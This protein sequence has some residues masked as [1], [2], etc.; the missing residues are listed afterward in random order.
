MFSDELDDHDDNEPNDENETD[1]DEEA[2]QIR[3]TT[4]SS[5]AMRRLPLGLIAIL[6][7][8]DPLALL[9]TFQHLLWLFLTLLRGLVW[10]FS[11]LD[12]V[13]DLVFGGVEWVVLWILRER[14]G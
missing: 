13:K 14:E 5:S 11:V 1:N 4:P 7:P 9:E 3:P 10:V 12:L 8:S 6:T 2:D